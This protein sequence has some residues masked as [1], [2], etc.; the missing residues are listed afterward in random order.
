[1]TQRGVRSF[2]HVYSLPRLSLAGRRRRLS[3]FAVKPN[4]AE[5]VQQHA[6]DAQSGSKHLPTGEPRETMADR[7][8]QLQDAIDNVSFAATYFP[9]SISQLTRPHSNSS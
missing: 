1:M 7:L 5:S 2:L 8:T 6:I 9:F 3:H 4:L